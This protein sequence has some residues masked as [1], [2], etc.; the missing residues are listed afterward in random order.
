[1]AAR[2]SC[3]A[4]GRP[5]RRWEEGIILKRTLE[6]EGAD[7]IYLADDGDRWQAL[8]NAVMNVGVPQNTGN[9]MTVDH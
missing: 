1:V 2:E 5:G 4:F 9:C 3:I 6:W 8:V 7:R